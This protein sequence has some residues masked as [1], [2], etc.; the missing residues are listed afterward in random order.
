[1]IVATRPTV[2]RRPGPD[3]PP[4]SLGRV[5]AAV[6]GSVAIAVAAGTLGCGLFLRVADAGVRDS[7]GFLTGAAVEVRSDGYAVHSTGIDIRNDTQVV[8]LPTRIIGQV[9]IEVDGSPDGIFVGVAATDDVEAY[10]DGVPHSAIVSVEGGRSVTYEY[11]L[12]HAA[13][14]PPTAVDIWQASAS[15]PGRQTLILDPRAGDWAVVVMRADGG[16]PVDAHVRVGATVPWVDDVAIVL[17]VVGVVLGAAGVVGVR[18][19]VKR[20][21]TAG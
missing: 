2:S 17:L 14:K 11:S 13:P 3:L 10:L 7:D 12:G 6:T 21:I 1:M 4:W 20:E 19:A 8:D 5:V 16:T 18:A 15:G 9:K